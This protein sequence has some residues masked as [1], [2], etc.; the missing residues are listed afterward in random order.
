MTPSTLSAPTSLA[1]TVSGTAEENLA[2]A[3][4]S[5]PHEGTQVDAPPGAEPLPGPAAS[6]SASPQ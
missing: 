6:K 4:A 2:A 1:P 5:A 3:T